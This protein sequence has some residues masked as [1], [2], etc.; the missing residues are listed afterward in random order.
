MLSM[1]AFRCHEGLR[2]SP[3]GPGLELLQSRAAEDVV[4]VAQV[5]VVIK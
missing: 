2:F 1:V 5:V 4:H 3:V